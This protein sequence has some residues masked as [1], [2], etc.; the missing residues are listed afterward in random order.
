[1][2]PVSQ[3]TGA[4]A[5][6]H[7]RKESDESHAEIGPESVLGLFLG[8]L[9][10]THLGCCRR[11]GERA[12]DGLSIHNDDRFGDG[13][14]YAILRHLPGRLALAARTPCSTQNADAT[15]VCAS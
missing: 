1:M 13:F 9:V 7:A 11:S 12:L 15:V 10:R 4:A 14:P 6:D 2:W 8:Q 3:G 5:S